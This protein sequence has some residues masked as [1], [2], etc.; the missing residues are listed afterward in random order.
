[1][2]EAQTKD[3]H[4]YRDHLHNLIKDPNFGLLLDADRWWRDKHPND[5]RP[6]A[7]FRLGSS[8]R[9]QKQFITLWELFDHPDDFRHCLKKL[10]EEVFW[11]RS[12]YAFSTIVSA[13]A[14]SRHILERLH[15]L[16]ETP[17]DKVRLELLH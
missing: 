11:I 14:T 7:A 12:K 16:I 2:S 5:E 15:P 8:E 10:A 9:F 4:S 3:P 13:T 6:Q 1:M 17:A